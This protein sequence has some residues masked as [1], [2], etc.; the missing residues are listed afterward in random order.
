MKELPDVQN[1]ND[2]RNIELDRA[3]VRRIKY[4]IT[5]R[6]KKREQ[7][8][9]V[10]NF[11]T[12]VHLPKGQKGVHMSRFPQ[13]LEKYTKTMFSL[14]VVENALIELKKTLDAQAAYLMADFPYFIIK[15]APASKMKSTI[16]VDCRFIGELDKDN[17]ARL[18]LEV[19][20]PVTTCCPCSKEISKYNAHN[21]KAYV[22]IK[23]EISG[24]T[25]V[26]IE[27]L[28]DIAERAASAPLY[29][30]LKRPDEKFVTEQMYENP[31][32]VEDVARDVAILLQKQKGIKS[33]EVDVESFESI[34]NH[35]AVAN[36]KE[37]VYE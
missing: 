1:S 27:D 23:V 14:Q 22:T 6:D 2:T 26:W 20:T 28:I 10:A 19:R 36:V 32:F 13:V 5:L 33:Y 12:A 18:F 11:E 17:N 37:E 24:D 30:V 9:T 16:H 35:S 21:Q 25:F 31:K 29:T 4:P 34:H 7:Q 3:G 8:T 15:S